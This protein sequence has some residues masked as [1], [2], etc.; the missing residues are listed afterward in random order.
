MFRVPISLKC[1]KYICIVYIY[2]SRGYSYCTVLLMKNKF[3]FYN[4]CKC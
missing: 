4:L 2:T 3:E 1:L